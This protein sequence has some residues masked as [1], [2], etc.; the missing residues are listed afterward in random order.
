MPFH[1]VIDVR[2]WGDFGIGTYIRNLATALSRLDHENRYTL[3]AREENRP[4]IARLGANFN[5]VPY[6][7]PDTDL[8][9]NF[10]FP[11]YLRRFN[12]DLYHIPLNS[13]AYWMPRPYV[14]TIHDMSSL[15]Y[16]SQSDLRGT[17]H[18]ERYRRGALRAARVIA[19]SNATR[20]DLQGVL[21]IPSNRIRTIYSAP[22]PAFTSNHFDSVHEQQVL[23][24]Y[25]IAWPFILYA[26]TVRPH[27]NVPRLVEAFA[28]L[29]CEFENHPEYK[30]LR[31]VIIGDEL[32]GNPSVRR[33]V[34][35][36][37]VEPFV[38]F[39]GFVPS[40]TLRVF[41][42]AASIFAFPSLNEG[43]GLAPL[44]AMACGTPVVASNLPSLVE[45][46]GDTAE[47]VTPDNV[48]DIARG[49]RE[50]LQDRRRQE[51]LR[52]AGPLHAKRFSWDATARDV[53]E[54]YRELI[55]ELGNNV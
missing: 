43:F 36:T 11:L 46:V 25:S 54:V 14:V 6:N 38:R 44:E 55:N 35:A 29:R 4:A 28:V 37:R 32:S 45:A 24:R 21:P 49:L 53:L 41:Y 19:V 5:S 52:W 23:E 50:L 8:A 3:I 10:T 51:A 20:R 12:A 34:I 17:L 22:D 13:V 27:K 47:L 30:D 33:A 2:R 18:E 39:L 31:L 7:R 16:R 42:R 26:G 1:A 40:E 15:L 9:H 48:F